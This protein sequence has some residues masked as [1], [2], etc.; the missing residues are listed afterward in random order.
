VSPVGPDQHRSGWF[1]FEGVCGVGV[2][3]MDC[4]RDGS[5][6][7]SLGARPP[8]IAGPCEHG[9]PVADEESFAGGG[10]GPAGCAAR[11]TLCSPIGQRSVS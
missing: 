3:Y 5:A 2:K 10:A 6:M 4:E 7:V 11:L 8:W 9:E 1:Q